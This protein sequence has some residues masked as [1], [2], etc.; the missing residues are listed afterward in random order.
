MGQA[1]GL[2]EWAKLGLEQRLRSGQGGG[3]QL[4]V[5]LEMVPVA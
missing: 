1:D 4:G 5:R 2:G 3:L